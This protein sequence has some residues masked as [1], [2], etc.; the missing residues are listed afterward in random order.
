L[1]RS[2]TQSSPAIQDGS[3][4]L[5]ETGAVVE[6]ILTKYG[7]GKLSVP[8]D[9]A[10]YADYLFYLHFANGSL[11]PAVVGYRLIT[12]SGLSE[13][14]A[15][16]FTKR[17]FKKYLEMLNDRLSKN[18][19]LAGEEFTAADCM[20]VFSL[21]TMR[22]FSPYSL[23]DYDGILA[24]LK[25][26]GEREGYRRAMAKCDPGLNPILGPEAS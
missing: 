26:V 23:K 13:S 1:N 17:N 19:W 22:T 4:T 25:K 3:V 24:Y 2:P 5:G 12:A 21:T 16:F 18:T 9:A 7:K 10:N 8:A 15:A 20:T 14:K 6:Y 11:Q